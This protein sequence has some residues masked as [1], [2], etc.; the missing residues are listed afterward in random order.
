MLHYFA[1]R[2]KMLGAPMCL[3]WRDKFYKS[4]CGL[5]QQL[6]TSREGA[7]LAIFHQQWCPARHWAVA[8][9]EDVPS[10]T[11]RFLSLSMKMHSMEYPFSWFVSAVPPLFPPKSLPTPRVTNK[12]ALMLCKRCSAVAKTTGVLSNTALVTNSEHSRAWSLW[13]EWSPFQLVAVYHIWI[14]P[15]KMKKSFLSEMNEVLQVWW[16][17]RIFLAIWSKVK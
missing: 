4:W 7:A 1:L 8:M 13:R 16:L 17:M 6:S 14:Q 5:T 15:F 12:R 3:L 9:L 2:N 11:P 10:P